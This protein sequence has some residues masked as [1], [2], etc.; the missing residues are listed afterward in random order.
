MPKLKYV[1]TSHFRKISKAD[2][3][4]LDIDHDALELARHDLPAV[5]NRNSVP[6]EA[7]V[8][9]QVAEWLTKNEPKDWKVVAEKA[10]GG[11]V[12][13]QGQLPVGDN[14]PK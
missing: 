12:A 13:G 1:G 10:E 9:D 11:Q 3:K 14:K 6:T 2:F 4:A 8:S 7:E 5:N